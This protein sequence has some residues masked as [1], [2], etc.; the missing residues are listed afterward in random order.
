M[1]KLFSPAPL[2]PDSG[3]AFVRIVVGG[4][5]IFHG[6]EVF[7]EEKMKGYLDWDSFKGF[8]SPAF[9]VYMGKVAEL[10]A[11]IF[12]TI[13]LFT[14]LASLVLIFTMLYISFFVGHGKV[15]YE[16]QHPFLFVLLGLVFF[17]MGSGPY[18]A[19]R[20]VLKKK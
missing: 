16:D 20:A 2:W 17:F 18:S 9:V 10:V 6:L 11:G 13:G 8:S 12:L 14:R 4:F 7:D 19:D 1:R 5:M 15:W 3:L